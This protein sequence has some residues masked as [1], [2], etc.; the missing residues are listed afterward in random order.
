MN[1]PRWIMTLA[2][3]AILALAPARAAVLVHEYALRGSLNDSVGNTPLTSFGGQIT[4]LGYIFAANQGLAFSAPAFSPV[5]YS[6]EFSFK[7]NTVSGDRKLVD[8]ANLASNLGAYDRNGVL[9]FFPSSAPGPQIIAANTSVHVVITRDNPSGV[10]NGYVN[11]QLSFSFN[12]AA[13]AA[14]AAGGAFRFFMDDNVTGQTE[15]SGGTV[16]YMRF[17]NGALTQGEVSA[18]YAAGPPLVVPEP[19][20]YA[21]L[22]LG[23]IVMAVTAFRHRRR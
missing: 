5:N 23:G 15:A 14:S 6:L 20:T 16:N 19:S 4:A 8:F 17:Y 13:G 9:N 7:L 21:L 2:C 11:G 22:S 10:V 18:L 1:A 12:D 3:A